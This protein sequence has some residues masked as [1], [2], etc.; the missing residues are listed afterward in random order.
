MKSSSSKYNKEYYQAN[1]EKLKAYNRKYQTTDK[2]RAYQR[3][4]KKT[5]CKTDKSKTYQKEY[6][7]EYYQANKEKL[8]AYGRE[9]GKKYKKIKKKEKN[10]GRRK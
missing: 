4:Y 1:K 10:N 3:E 7:K 6:Q 9:Y 5:Y 2:Y 8:K